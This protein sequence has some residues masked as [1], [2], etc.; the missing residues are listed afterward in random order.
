MH[1]EISLLIAGAILGGAAVLSIARSKAHTSV[2]E[3]WRRE[4]AFMWFLAGL[5][6]LA[7][8]VR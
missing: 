8:L 5:L 4:G 2:K 6:V 1:R 3:W 7:F